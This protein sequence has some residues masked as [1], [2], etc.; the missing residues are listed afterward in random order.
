MSRYYRFNHLTVAWAILL[1][2]VGGL[3][4]GSALSA[5]G[6]LQLAQ[7][8]I[9]FDGKAKNAIATIK[10]QSD[11]VYLVKSSMMLTPNPATVGGNDAP[12]IV[13]PP[14]FRLEP[15][16]QNTVLVMRNGTADLPT[17]RESV[18]YLSLLGIPSTSALSQEQSEGVSAQISV[19]IQLIIKLFYRPV[20]LAQ[21]VETAPGKLAFRQAGQH[22][23]VNNPTPYF[24]TLAKLSLDGKLLDVRN[25]GAM[26]APFSQQHYPITGRPQQVTWSVIN[27]YGGESAQYQAA[28]AL[29][30]EA[31]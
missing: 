15:N 14:L 12:F 8:R 7:T 23:Y 3:S 2:T 16:S 31:L 1:I 30:R 11:H 29:N 19:G 27:D 25:I 22:L 13:T 20:G 18:F 28:M 10:N 5:G 6:G 21:P 24:V 4:V 26:I 17:D 9:I